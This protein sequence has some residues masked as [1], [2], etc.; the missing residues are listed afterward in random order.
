MNPERRRDGL[1]LGGLCR[2]DRQRLVR[3]EVD[4]VLSA[5]GVSAHTG[6]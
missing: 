2:K 5:L 4:R 3:L 1:Q 6:P